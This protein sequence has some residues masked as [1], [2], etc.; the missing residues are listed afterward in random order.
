MTI[1]RKF[2]ILAHKTMRVRQDNVSQKK[3]KI[4][5]KIKS[6]NSKTK[7]PLMMVIKLST[8]DKLTNQSKIWRSLEITFQMSEYKTKIQ[9]LQMKNYKAIKNSFNS[10]FPKI[11]LKNSNKK[12]TFK[13]LKINASKLKLQIQI[14]R[15]VLRKLK[16]NAKSLRLRRKIWSKTTLKLSRRMLKLSNK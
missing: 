16:R 11:R 3:T 8:L 12:M 14:L 9:S 2:M 13:S 15:K 1:L 4:D 7:L 6:E 10:Y 5:L